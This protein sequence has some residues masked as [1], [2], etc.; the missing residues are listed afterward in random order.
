MRTLGFCLLIGI[1]GLAL[2]WLSGQLG[3]WWVTP[4]V[5]VLIGLLLRPTTNR[6]GPRLPGCTW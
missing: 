4:L 2:T 1:I 5:G 3:W 6:S